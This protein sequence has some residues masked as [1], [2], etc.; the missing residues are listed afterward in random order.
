MGTLHRLSI[1]TVR[2]RGQWGVAFVDADSGEPV[3]I[4][5]PDEDPHRLVAQIRRALDAGDLERVDAEVERA[6]QLAADGKG[7]FYRDWPD[8]FG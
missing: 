3:I 4:Y 6:A 8:Q 2:L 1:T 5:L 7:V